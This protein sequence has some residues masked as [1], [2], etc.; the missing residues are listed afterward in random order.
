MLSKAMKPMPIFK[1]SVLCKMLQPFYSLEIIGISASSH[2]KVY[3]IC[4]NSSIFKDSDQL[5][6]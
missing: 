3:F 6:T 1:L 4:I 2:T 5:S